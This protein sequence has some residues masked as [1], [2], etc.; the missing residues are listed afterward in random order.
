MNPIFSSINKIIMSINNLIDNLD[1][2]Y[3]D[4]IRQMFFMIF[5][6]LWVLAAIFGIIMG[7]NAASKGGIS[8][9]QETNDAF[10]IEIQ[11]EHE[12]SFFKDIL[13]EEMKG[14]MAKPEFPKESFI[15]NEPLTPESNDTIIEAD[16]FTKSDTTNVMSETSSPI[17]AP[18]IIDQ[19]STPLVEE[20]NSRQ[21]D[22]APAAS[23]PVTDKE[24]SPLESNNNSANEKKDNSEKTD[25]N[26][27]DIM[28]NSGGIVQ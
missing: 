21:N 8:L 20:K 7:R 23:E 6:I 22:P 15:K 28:D 4:M 24:S 26:S 13:A 25:G 14:E 17:D 5:F 19:N 10:D 11:L 12:D 3:V 1:K 9:I 27:Y 2:R 16:K 18:R